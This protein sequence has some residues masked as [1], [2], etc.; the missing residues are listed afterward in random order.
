MASCDIA[1]G[2]LEACKDAMSGLDTAYF[3]NFGIDPSDVTIVSN[4][5]TAVSG[6]STLYK[7]ELKGANTLETTINSSRDNGTTFFD[8]VLT[9]QLKTQD[10]T[11]HDTVK[12]LSWGRPH[13]IVHT[14]NDQYFMVGLNR[15]ADLTA[16]NISNGTQAG[17]F[18]GYSL[19]FT[20]QEKLPP[21]FI[22]ATTETQLQ[23]V[24]GG[25]SI[26]SQ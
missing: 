8:Q 16:G 2:R 26:V 4:E 12:L 3:I 13:I 10:V 6:V 1:H 7:F 14:R 23:A 20:G 15:G 24:F 25:A 21:I 5:I 11:A 22:D 19:T 9:M 17:D 18:N